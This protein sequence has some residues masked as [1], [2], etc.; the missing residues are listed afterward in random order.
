[1]LLKWW[2]WERSS[3]PGGTGCHVYLQILRQHHLVVVTCKNKGRQFVQILCFHDNSVFYACVH[4]SFV[5]AN[6]S[7]YLKTGT[8]YSANL[9]KNICCLICPAFPNC[10]VIKY[11]G[12]MFTHYTTLAVG[13][14][15]VTLVSVTNNVYGINIFVYENSCISTRVLQYIHNDIHIH[16]LGIS[17][18]IF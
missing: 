4:N 9:Q 5:L 2:L 14:A 1:M 6:I 7:R 12:Y 17:F 11:T 18:W 10:C 15:Q 3:P 13:E 16:V 8:I